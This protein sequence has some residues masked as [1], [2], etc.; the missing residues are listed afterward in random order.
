MENLSVQQSNEKLAHDN[1]VEAGKKLAEAQIKLEKAEDLIHEANIRLSN[2]RKFESVLKERQKKLDRAFFLLN[3]ERLSIR[4][5]QLK[6]DQH[7]LLL[8]DN[9]QHY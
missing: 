3:K 6:A 9:I 7:D 8:Q 5:R 2:A 1:A 4:Q